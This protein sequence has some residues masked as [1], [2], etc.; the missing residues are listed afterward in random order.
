MASGILRCSI[1]SVIEDK[2]LQLDSP[3]LCELKELR[4]NILKKITEEERTMTAFDEFGTELISTLNSIFTPHK[5]YRSSEAKRTKYWS[6]F[7]QVRVTKLPKLWTKFLSAIHIEANDQLLQQSVNQRVFEM[8]LPKQFAS[9]SSS[10]HAR[11]YS[12]IKDE[13]NVLQYVGG[14]ICTSCSAKEV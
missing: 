7:H 10:V 11:N 13:L 5:A 14:Y 4:S 8:L 12:L 9:K 2:E 3:R 1:S 6:G